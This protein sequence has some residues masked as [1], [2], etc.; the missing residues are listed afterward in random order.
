[1][2]GFFRVDQGI[3][4][5]THGIATPCQRT[6]GH[7]VSRNVA[8]NTEFTAGNADNDL[9]LDRQNRCGVGLTLCR[10]AVLHRP[11]DFACGCVK[12]NNCCISLMQEDHAIGCRHATIHRVTA[13]H[14]DHIGILFRLID[15][16]DGA[17]IGKIERIHIV[18]ERCMDVHGVADHER[19]ALMTAQHTGREC[20]GDLQVLDIVLVD[21]VEL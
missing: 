10:I 21:L 12:R 8:A 5:R 9:V 17:V 1:M 4:V 15:P 20:P 19:G 14:R 13:H 2:G 3:A 11:F 16:F 6:I 18:G 7:V